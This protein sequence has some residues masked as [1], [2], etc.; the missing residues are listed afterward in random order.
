[1]EERTLTFCH[2]VNPPFD[3]CAS[4]SDEALFARAAVPD[5]FQARVNIFRFK[6]NAIILSTKNVSN[7]V[8]KIS[9]KGKQTAVCQVQAK[10]AGI[11]V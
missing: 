7:T 9:N 2:F 3:R 8:T 4:Q 11:I 6:I 1:M 5:G 10:I